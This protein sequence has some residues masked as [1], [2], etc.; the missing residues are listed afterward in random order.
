MIKNN[1]FQPRKVVLQKG[2]GDRTAEFRAYVV[3]RQVY[4]FQGSLVGFKYEDEIL[5]G[6][7]ALFEVETHELKT[8]LLKAAFT[9]LPPKP[10]PHC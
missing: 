1:K 8:Q 10:C 4:D 7:V 2:L 6:F 3:L 5:L 9:C